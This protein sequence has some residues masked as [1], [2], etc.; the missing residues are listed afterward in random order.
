MTP[1]SQ[2]LCV[3][4]LPLY[5]WLSPGYYHLSAPPLPLG[6]LGL[7]E[8]DHSD[9]ARSLEP[10][11]VVGRVEVEAMLEVSGARHGR[12]HLLVALRRPSEALHLL[13]GEEERKLVV[14]TLLPIRWHT[15]MWCRWAGLCGVAHDGRAG[16]CGPGGKLWHLEV[17]QLPLA[18]LGQLVC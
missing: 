17:E 12:A 3:S 16:C 15:A 10:L 13:S 4:A 11:L 2:P 1:P 5:G 14:K 6:R 18:V 7:R 9:R 8:S